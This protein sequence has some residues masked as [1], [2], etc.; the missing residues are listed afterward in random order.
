M[1]SRMHPQLRG[2]AHSPINTMVKQD[3]IMPSAISASQAGS[4][5]T[6]PPVNAVGFS[7]RGLKPRGTVLWKLRDVSRLFEW[8]GPLRPSFARPRLPTSG[9]VA[10]TVISD[11]RQHRI[12]QRRAILWPGSFNFRCEGSQSLLGSFETYLARLD[13]VLVGR[14]G[15]HRAK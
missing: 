3:E 13:I 15:H 11:R 6:N 5:W 1:L 2:R 7:V 12:D 10:N 8:G 9:T 4:E 14:N